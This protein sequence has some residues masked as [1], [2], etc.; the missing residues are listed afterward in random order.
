MEGLSNLLDIAADEGKIHGSHVSPTTPE[1]THLLFAGDS[2]LFFK[3]TR[4]ETTYVKG[5]LDSYAEISGQSINYQK[6]WVLYSSNV[7]KDKQLEL[8]AILGVHNDISNSNY[9]GL[10][11][12][13]GR[14][15]K[16]V[17]G[18][19][20]ERVC[21]RI[22]SW[23]AKSISRAGKSIMLKN[24]A[25]EFPAYCMSCF[26]LP[27]SLSQE[28]ERCFNNYWWS[29]G[30][31]QGK[32]VKWLSW[33]SMSMAKSRGGLGFRSLYGFNV[34]LLGKHIWKC[35][36]NPDMLVSRVLKA[37]Y[38]PNTHILKATKGQ[39]SSF[40]W[41]GIWQAKEI[42][43]KGFRWVVGDGQN[44]VATKDQWLAKK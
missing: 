39:G 11:S 14:L 5:I 19:L 29:S 31:G 34:A 26:L 16:R 43:F 40:L 2:F 13:I 44:I 9:L 41:T 24:I 17:F 12:L 3:A 28:I 6:S 22:Q 42:L 21:K 36:Q 15:K 38:F 7:R 23:S 30:S 35:I 33:E 18:Y 8:S 27:K 25:Q 1:I 10:P 20:K 37:R 4:E 32:G